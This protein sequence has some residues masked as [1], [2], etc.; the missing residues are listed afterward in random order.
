[1]YDYKTQSILFDKKVYTSVPNKIHKIIHFFLKHPNWK[2]YKTHE[3]NN[4][5]RFRIYDPSYLKKRG[6]DKVVTKRISTGILLVL[7]MKKRRMLD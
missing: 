3:T 6:Y 5:Y 2:P 4:Y 1:M 7:Y